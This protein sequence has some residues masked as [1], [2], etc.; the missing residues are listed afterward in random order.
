VLSGV[1]LRTSET[2]ISAAL[3]AYVHASEKNWLFYTKKCGLRGNETK[4]TKDS[5]YEKQTTAEYTAEV[6]R[7]LL[8]QLSVDP[9]VHF[10]VQLSWTDKKRL[11]KYATLA[12]NDGNE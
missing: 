2:E 11:E 3:W 12:K 5:N 8:S 9:S 4:P 10:F 1:R 7:M 6:K